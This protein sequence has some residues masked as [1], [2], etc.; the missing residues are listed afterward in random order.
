LPTAEGQPKGS[1]NILVV[2]GEVFQDPG[3]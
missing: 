1:E 2:T 3:L